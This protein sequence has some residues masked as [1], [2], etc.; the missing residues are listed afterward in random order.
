MTV[1]EYFH[2]LR[3]YARDLMHYHV[4]SSDPARFEVD[5]QQEQHMETEG[6]IGMYVDQIISDIEAE[7]LGEYH[8]AVDDELLLS[9]TDILG[10]IMS[11][12]SKLYDALMGVEKVCDDEICR[13]AIS[14]V[15]MI[16]DDIFS[17]IPEI[18][19]YVYYGE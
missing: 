14:K 16:H 8:F 2:Q 19:G 7:L 9:L 1:C 12:R 5:L 18:A 10:V 6:K 11:V 4:Y 17:K 13:M 3:V 15:K